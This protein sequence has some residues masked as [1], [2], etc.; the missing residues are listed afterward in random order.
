MSVGVGFT[1]EEIR[2]FV[3]EYEVQPYGTKAA[4]LAVSGVSYDRLRNWRSA[5][6]EGDLER[7]LVPRKGM[8]MTIDQGGRRALE[9]QRARER[10]AQEAEVTRLHARVEELEGINAALGKAI[11]LLHQMSEQE[12]AATSTPSDPID[13]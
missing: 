9:R 10:A 8:P 13:S 12:P 2:E 6:F 1:V 7:G 3:H 11:G 5:L 4:W